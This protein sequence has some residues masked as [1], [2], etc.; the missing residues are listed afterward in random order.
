MTPLQSI[1]LGLIQGMTEFLP[2]SSSA[3]LV[4]FPYFMGWEIP[5]KDAF[6]FNVLVQMA[7][8]LSVILYFYRDLMEIMRGFVV[9][10]KRR[11]LWQE[12]E[13]YLGWL[14][15]L[16]TLPAG[17][18]GLLLKGQI[19]WAFS[20]PMAVGIFLWCTALILSISEKLGRRSRSLE[21]LKWW[22]ALWIG[23]TQIAALFP[24]ISRSGAT[25][26]GGMCRGLKRAEAARFS[27][28][29]SIP[30]MLAA[31][32]M[33]F[34]DLIE[35][36]NSKQLLLR[37]LPGFFSAMVVGYISIHWLLKYLKQRSFYTFAIY[38]AVLGTVVIIVQIIH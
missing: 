15:L 30:I 25:M 14:I 19:E 3:H 13:G 28:L 37:Y 22:D 23:V 29:M 8:L 1:L 24:G 11:K 4:L 31:G 20:S 36:N 2:I 18:I 5:S 34:I 17:L 16:A 6:I 33:S 12:P 35:L 26:A 9:S 21:D 10:L 7:T 38:C 32:T 27:F